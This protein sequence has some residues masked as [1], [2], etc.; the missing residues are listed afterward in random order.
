MSI[1]ELSK[2]SGVSVSH[3]SNI[4]KGL[5]YPTLPTLCKIA[6]ALDVDCSELFSCDD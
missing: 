1:C 5:K 3:I 4:E 2:L 6:K